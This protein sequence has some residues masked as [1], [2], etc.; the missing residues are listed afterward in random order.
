[1]ALLLPEYP[2]LCQ[3]VKVWHDLTK[4]AIRAGYSKKT[5]YSQGQR[6]LKNAEIQRAIQ[7]AMDKRAVRVG[8]KA[9]D[10]LQELNR[11]AMAPMGDKPVTWDQKLRALE[12]EMKHLKLLGGDEAEQA[13][14]TTEEFDRGTAGNNDGPLA[15]E[16]KL[17]TLC[18]PL[19]IRFSQIIS[20]Y[21]C[22][23][24]GIWV[25]AIAYLKTDRLA[26]RR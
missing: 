22:V 24:A 19:D 23:I 5:A 26:G 8:L 9:D 1:M 20:T 10:V 7:Q 4:A 18:N 12:P 11:A 25:G 21:S 6:L 13:R 15:T 14:H 16:G 3:V 17:A 2:D